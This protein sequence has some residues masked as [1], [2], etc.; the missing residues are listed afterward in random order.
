MPGRIDIFKRIVSRLAIPVPALRAV[1]IRRL[2]IGRGEPCDHRVIYPTIHMDEAD[3]GELLMAGEAACGLA[4]KAAGRI[5]LATGKAPLAPGIIGQA[6][7]DGAALIAER[8]GGAEMILVIIARKQPAI[9]A[10]D[11]H[12]DRL[13]AGLQ[14]VGPLDD[15]ARAGELLRADA[16]GGEIQRLAAWRHLLTTRACYLSK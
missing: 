8:R 12:A 3:F 6:L 14:I 7:D 16:A 1:L 10:L 5:V 13:A 11:P 15:A 4:A 9:G 2:G